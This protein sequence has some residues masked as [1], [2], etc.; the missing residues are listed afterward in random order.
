[1]WCVK[2]PFTHRKH[3]VDASEMMVIQSDDMSGIPDVVSPNPGA[4]H[5]RRIAWIAADPE[6]L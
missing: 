6:E 4:W 5:G 2:P 1:M 3:S